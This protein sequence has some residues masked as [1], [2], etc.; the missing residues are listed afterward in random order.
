MQNNIT[1]KK[2]FTDTIVIKR[3]RGWRSKMM[4]AIKSFPPATLENSS[5]KAVIEIVITLKAVIITKSWR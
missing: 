1:I 2:Y 4:A 5:H 3:E